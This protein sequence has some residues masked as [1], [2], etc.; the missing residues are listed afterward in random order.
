MPQLSL[1][2]SKNI[3]MSVLDFRE[4]FEA[5]HEV[6]RDA[7]NL[8]IS[9]CHSGVVQEDFSYIG[10]GDAKKTKVYLE[11]YWVENESRRVV[12]KQLALDLM[13]VLERYMV[14]QIEKQ[15]LICIPR[16]RIANLGVL[17]EDYHISSAS[18]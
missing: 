15:Q 17:G 6:L 16:V 11:L 4:L 2:I 1:K 10:L 14:P 7:P 3:D 5:L 18:S 12:K 13:H 9:T 8:D